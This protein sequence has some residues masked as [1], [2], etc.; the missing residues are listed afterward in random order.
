M[1]VMTLQERGFRYIKRGE[2]FRWMHPSEIVAGDVDCT[3][4][5]DEQFLAIVIGSPA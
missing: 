1:S 2:S 4:L 3:E 5:T